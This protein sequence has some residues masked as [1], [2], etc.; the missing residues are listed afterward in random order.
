MASTNVSRDCFN[1]T[2]VNS[3]NKNQ[4]NDL[5]IM[6]FC[7]MPLFRGVDLPPLEGLLTRCT[8]RLFEKNE[9]LLD[10]NQDNQFFYVI[11]DGSVL[12]YSG[13]Y[14]RDDTEILSVG[15][16]V[17]EMSMFD[18]NKPSVCVKADNR[19]MT[20]AMDSQTLW[21]MIDLSHQMAR[22]LLHLLSKRERSNNAE[23][24]KSL[25]F[26]GQDKEPVT[27]DALTGLHNRHWLDELSLRLKG[28]LL[29]DLAPLCLIMLDVDSLEQVNHLYGQQVGDR[30]LK[31]VATAL[32]Q[33]L[34]PNDMVGRY[35]GEEFV[36]ILPSA[37]IVTA[38]GVVERLRHGIEH[39]ACSD[40][41]LPMVTVSIG[42]AQ[43]DG[44]QSIA[45]LISAADAA[46]YQ[47][48]EKG[49]NRCSS[50]G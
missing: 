15:D 4:S 41:V 35:G 16:C 43:W 8:I 40:S 44:C 9:L 46:L 5:E 36:V 12:A 1:V 2:D 23:R 30:V 29:G 14:L 18:G 34:R 31:Q 27:N 33:H 47:A 37:S 28:R 48:K 10:P 21:E 7:D 49:R 6:D 50:V 24:E 13:N 26:E 38:E 32:Q 39:P 17:G 3:S 25:L 11:L 19:V 45:Q 42:I 20:L 22:N